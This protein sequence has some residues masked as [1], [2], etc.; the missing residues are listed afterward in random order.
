MNH[1]YAFAIR[2]MPSPTQMPILRKVPQISLSC[3][4]SLQMRP[5]DG[6]GSGEEI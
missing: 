5:K 3:L 6:P 4:M 2:K 1:P